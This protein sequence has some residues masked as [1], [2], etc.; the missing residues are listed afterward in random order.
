M[1]KRYL[2]KIIATDNDGLQMISACCAG[3]E[4]KVE[5][6]KYLKNNKV[7]LLSFIRSK[8]ETDD[9]KKIN[10]ICKFEFVDQVKSK[11]IIQNDLIQKLELIAIDYLKNN[12]NYEISL[13]FTNNAYITLSTEIIE[14]TLDD[15]SEINL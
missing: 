13:I 14:V 1:S 15:Q 2:S 8:I 7:F 4:I 9:S 11:N 3:A 5:N 10:S 12:K 6:I